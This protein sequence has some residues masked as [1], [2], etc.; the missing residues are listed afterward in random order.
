[1]ADL[2]ITHLTAGKIPMVIPHFKYTSPKQSNN[3]T[4][5]IEVG[6]RII[7]VIEDLSEFYK[8]FGY[9]LD[10]AKAGVLPDEFIWEEYIKNSDYTACMQMRIIEYLRMHSDAFMKEFGDQC[11]K[12]ISVHE[13]IRAETGMECVACRMKPF[14]EMQAQ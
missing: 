5:R 14:C 2:P 4:A 12:W 13:A 7:H 6:V 1:L 3:L 9:S 11:D 8:V 10:M